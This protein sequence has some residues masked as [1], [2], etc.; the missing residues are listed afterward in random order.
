MLDTAYPFFVINF[1][2]SGFPHMTKK[3]L[4]YKII[5]TFFFSENKRLTL[6]LQHTKLKKGKGTVVGIIKIEFK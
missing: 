4:I 2:N 5:S 3:V 1:G 6:F